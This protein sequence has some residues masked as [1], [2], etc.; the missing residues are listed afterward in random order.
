MLKS[1]VFLLLL[2]STFTS[3]TSSW[4]TSNLSKKVTEELFK[5]NQHIFAAQTD[6]TYPGFIVSNE[7][8]LS[9]NFP[10][11]THKSDLV[12]GFGTTINWDIA[13]MTNANA[14]LLIDQSPDV[15]LAHH[16]F[17]RTLWLLAETP[18]EFIGLL[19]GI[20]ISKTKGKTLEQAFSMI[21]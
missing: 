3:S 18:A 9:T 6:G 7:E 1:L 4:A 11:L 10:I 13:G 17:W 19:A 21:D 12:A 2:L 20:P 15:I 5:S 16:F 8:G 14:L